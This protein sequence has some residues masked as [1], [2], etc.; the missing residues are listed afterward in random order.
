MYRNQTMGAPQRGRR[1]AKAVL[2]HLLF[3]A[4]CLSS[5]DGRPTLARNRGALYA[6]TPAVA[7]RGGATMSALMASAP[8]QKGLELA[9]IA[10][11]GALIRGRLD[12]A[13]LS[14]LLLKA[15]VPAVILSSLSALSLSVELLGFVG[16]GVLLA[17]AQLGAGQTAA[18]AL[19]G[20]DP[21]RAVTRRTSA[22]QVGTMA[23]V[24]SSLPYVR[25]FAGEARMGHAAL[26]D[27]P[28]K[29]YVLLL[30]PV[31]LSFLGDRAGRARPPSGS[32]TPWRSRARAFAR[33]LTDPFNA[34]ILS[35]LLMASTG[36]RLESLGFVGAAV[37]M[38]ASAQTPVLFLLIGMKFKISGARP[39]LVA[40]L[41]LARHGL[42]ALCVAVFFR[43][44][45]V[46]DPGARL[47]AVLSSQAASSIIAFGQVDAASRRALG[48]D[49][50]L[51]FE[52]VSLSFPLTI[53]LNTIACVAGATYV[54]RIGQVGAAL[55]AGSAAVYLANRRQIDDL[56]DP[57][58]SSE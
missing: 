54:D 27:L 58:I 51:A 34:A 12:A 32:V 52:I 33:E 46:V 24:L 48:Y 4:L 9:T 30:M 8:M 35:G 49:G 10:A 2:H 22:L 38:L 7:M 44:A 6:R 45:G 50:S 57:H 43:V 31:V 15:L 5:V 3:F 1:A 28:T 39:A 41:L 26:V 20:R 19:L 14:A 29:A 42:I 36:T 18:F 56:R 13:A 11:F 55:L 40:A 17:L 23:P 16:M 21:A 53:V 47:T 37:R 25:E